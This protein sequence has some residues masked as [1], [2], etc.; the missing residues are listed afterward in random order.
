MQTRTDALIK[1]GLIKAGL[2]K[3]GVAKH[4]SGEA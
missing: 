1:A 2:I 3:T 4:E